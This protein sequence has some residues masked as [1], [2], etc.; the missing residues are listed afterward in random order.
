MLGAEADEAAAA[1]A[2][3][4]DGSSYVQGQTRCTVAYCTWSSTRLT[5]MGGGGWGWT[6]T[7]AAEPPDD[8]DCNCSLLD[9]VLI[10]SNACELVDASEAVLAVVPASADG[11][12]L[13]PVGVALGAA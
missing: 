7:A 4:S 1:D 12:A 3:V 11:W 13:S 5:G 10:P 9:W 8:L 2:L 6:A